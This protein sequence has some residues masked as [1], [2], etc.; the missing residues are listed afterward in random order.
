MGST[1]MGSKVA[2]VPLRKFKGS[3]L[4][5]EILT[6]VLTQEGRFSLLADTFQ[7]LGDASR[8]KIVWLLSLGEKNVSR[9][10]EVLQ[11]S[12]PA[13]SHHLRMLRN[14]RLVKVNKVGRIAFYSLDDEH[15]DH[16]LIEGMN[17][18]E[19]LLDLPPTRS[20]KQG[21]KLAELNKVKGRK[22]ENRGKGE[23]SL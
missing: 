4:E 11:M 23:V 5:N 19:D 2:T 3:V 17:H 15:I 10:T 14:L 1:K 20:S 13:V 21:K 16:L 6:D 7:A 18:V 12:Q 22:K 8:V 9:L